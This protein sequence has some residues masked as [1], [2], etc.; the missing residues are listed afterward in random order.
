MRQ[1]CGNR[2][3]EREGAYTGRGEHEE[4]EGQK[5]TREKKQGGKNGTEGWHIVKKNKK[6]KTCFKC[7][8]KTIRGE[9]LGGL[10]EGVGAIFEARERRGEASMSQ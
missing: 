9:L 6:N 7:E 2:E 8:H 1:R 10:G 4:K 3:R 5:R